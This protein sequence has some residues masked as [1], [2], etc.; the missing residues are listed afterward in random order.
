MPGFFYAMTLPFFCAMQTV[1]QSKT[2]NLLRVF[3][4]W[5]KQNFFFRALVDK[6]CSGLNVG[7]RI[8]LDAEAY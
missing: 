4:F 1:D 5:F 2:T 8:I 6:K 7:L 3:S